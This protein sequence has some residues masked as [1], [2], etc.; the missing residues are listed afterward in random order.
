MPYF[1]FFYEITPDY[2]ERTRVSSY[3]AFFAK[4][5]TL[6]AGWAWYITQLPLFKDAHGVVSPLLGAQALSI[7][8]ALLTVVLG[9][10]PALLMKEHFYHIA[11]RQAKTKLVQNLKLTMRN[12]PFLALTGFAVFFAAGSFL[13]WG[14][15]FY[16]RLYWV[17]QGDVA[18]AAKL[19]GTEATIG[20]ALGFASIPV[21]QWLCHRIGKTKTLVIAM[22]LCVLAVASRWL[23]LNPAYP[24]FSLLSNALMAPAITCIWQLL[25]AL[26]A[27]CVDFDELQSGTRNEGTYAAV[28]SWFL[29]ASCTA[30]LALAGPLVVWCGF[31]NGKDVIQSS[32]TIQAIRLCDAFLPVALLLVGMVALKFYPLTAARM[33]EIRSQLE[34]RR[35]KV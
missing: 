20:T 32:N 16:S 4:L 22:S 23:I 13:V 33:A 15:E 31:Q 29:K 25:P 24:W 34:S 27:D 30:G 8:L 3:G 26:A 35:G 6:I 10:L 2:N 12:R 1:S 28:F 7:V 17:C 18:L 9:V 21:T 5:A 19:S 11:S 14:L